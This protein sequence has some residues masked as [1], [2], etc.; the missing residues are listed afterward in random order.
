M[1]RLDYLCDMQLT[2]SESQAQARPTGGEEGSLFALGRGTVAGER[3]LGAVRCANHAHRRSDGAMQPDVNGVIITE[4]NTTILFHMQGLTP[5]LPTPD[6]PMGDQ[7]SWISFET[8]AEPYRWLNNL[9]CV[10]EG[11]VRIQ[12][13]QGASG[14]VR[15]YI[16]VNEMVTV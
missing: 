14:T 9:R 1:M 10:L 3:L 12:P 8:D 5:W 2:L 4:D 7:V 13:G 11:V 16:C 6:G 15:V